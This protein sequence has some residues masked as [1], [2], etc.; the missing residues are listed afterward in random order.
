MNNLSY[1]LTRTAAQHGNR[2]ATLHG[3][4]IRNYRWLDDQAGRLAS[5]LAGIA[6]A[7][8]APAGAT[9]TR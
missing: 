4:S 6:G 7:G 2:T 3:D 1:L 9:T 8:G 5:A